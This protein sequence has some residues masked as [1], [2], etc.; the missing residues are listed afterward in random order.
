MDIAQVSGMP[1]VLNCSVET[2]LGM[3]PSGSSDSAISAQAVG[4]AAHRPCHMSSRRADSP[5]NRVNRFEP[6]TPKLFG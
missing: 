1:D 6:T 2:E 3:T 5:A 4:G